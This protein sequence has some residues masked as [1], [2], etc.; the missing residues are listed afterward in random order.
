MYPKSLNEWKI[1][2]NQLE[3]PISAI[4]HNWE[5]V[6]KNELAMLSQLITKYRQGYPL[7]YLLKYTLIGN[8]KF[9]LDENVLIPRPETEELIEIIKQEDDAP[10][11]LLDVGCGSGFIGISLSSFFQHLVMTDISGEALD[12]CQQNCELNA[13]NNYQLIQSHLLEN[14]TVLEDYWLVANLPYVPE[15]DIAYEIK[16]KTEFEPDFAIYSGEDGLELFYKL[17]DQIAKLENKPT[18]MFFELDP[19]NILEAAGCI[20]NKLFLKSQ[21][22]KDMN[23]LDRFL[24]CI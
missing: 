12:I 11:T 13:I 24:V 3:K 19:R 6:S 4:M 21:I 1:V 16:N 5:T 22:L 20:N 2:A 18:K 7:D 23:D 9:K 10:P 8:Y 17:I 14:I 15:S